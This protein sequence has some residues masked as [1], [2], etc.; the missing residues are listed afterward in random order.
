MC[1][2]GLYLEMYMSYI[3]NMIDK[4]IYNDMQFQ[5]DNGAN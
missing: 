5:V 1:V 4:T 3:Q 2:G